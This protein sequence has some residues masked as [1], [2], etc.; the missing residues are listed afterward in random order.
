[1]ATA[2][3]TE[4]AQWQET[5]LR[6]ASCLRDGFKNVHPFE[7]DG[8]VSPTVI[9]FR[10]AFHAFPVSA[11][12][13]LVDAGSVQSPG[14]YATIFLPPHSSTG[15]IWTLIAHHIDE[16]P[17]REVN[18]HG[19]VALS[20]FDS[21]LP[22]LSERFGLDDRYLEDLTTLRFSG[23]RT[24]DGSEVV[25]FVPYDIRERPEDYA[26][27]LTHELLT[28]CNDALI[29]RFEKKVDF[30]ALYSL[31][32]DP[33]LS[34]GEWTRID[35]RTS[36]FVTLE[37][38]EPPSFEERQAEVSGIQLIPKVP[39]DIHVTLRRAKDAYV[40][41]YFRYDLFTVAVHYA[42]LALE[43]AIKAR[44]SASLPQSV[45]ISCGKETLQL[46]FPSHSKIANICGE[47]PWRGR[48]ILVS[49]QRF[50]WSCR[51]ILDWLEREKIV[52]KW[53]RQCLTVGLQMRNTLSHVEHP[54]T[55]TPSSETL[56]RT[57]MLINKLFHS[58]P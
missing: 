13:L 57:A 27:Y 22:L 19:K 54:S 43:A 11:D 1:M 35:D 15:P 34:I 24:L 8:E 5:L 41:G 4:I 21:Y 56:W 31:R 39:N 28:F 53:E 33:I 51:A 29:R 14:H 32:P 10:D 12:V 44:W 16:L 58:L 36:C 52:T 20:E 38:D 40:C 37:S 46:Q 48:N 47:K 9:A 26:R 6:V 2:S 18:F 17:K 42:S 3:A 25:H 7:D 55:D 50:P 49:G 23:C 45:V 30:N